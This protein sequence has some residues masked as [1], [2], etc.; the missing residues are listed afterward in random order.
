MEKSQPLSQIDKQIQVWSLELHTFDVEKTTTISK[1]LTK[2]VNLVF[3]N[4]SFPKHDEK[5]LLLGIDRETK[6]RRVVVTWP[7]IFTNIF[8]LT[9]WVFLGQITPNN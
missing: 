9:S 5:E 4:A 2:N 7:Q 3:G 6:V 1:G 8:K